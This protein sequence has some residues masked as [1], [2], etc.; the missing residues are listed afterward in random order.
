MLDLVST[1]AQEDTPPK[2]PAF[3]RH[4]D[5]VPPVQLSDYMVYTEG[6]PY[7][8]YAAMR[9]NAPVCWCTED[10]FS[11]FWA[12]TRY[13][14]IRK[15]ELDTQTFSSQRG[16]INMNYGPQET[17]H[18]LLNRA[19]FD[20]M[21]CLDAPVHLQLRR[22][23]MP[24]FTAN[25]VAELRRKVDA[26]V[27]SLLDAMAAKGPTLDLV[28]N[29]SAELP[30]FT[31]SEIL[32]IPEMD[33]PK[34]VRWMHYLEQAQ[35]ALT[36][37]AVGDMDPAFMFEFLTN[38]QEMFDYGQSML[39][40]RR[41]DPR[42][43]LLSAIAN[44]EIDGAPLPDEFLDGSWL[45]IVFAG[46]DTTRNSISGAMRLLNAFPDQR[47]KLVTTPSLL[48][49]FVHESIRMVSPVIYMRRTATRD[50][51]IN[52]QKIAEGEKVLM[53][54][55]AANRD[56]A[57]FTNPDQFDITRNN[58]RDHIAFGLGPHV[59]LGQRVANMQLEAAFAQ[60]LARF[61]GITCTGDMEIAPSNFVH[62]ISRLEVNL[63]ER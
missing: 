15:V 10:E 1:T 17:R 48:P 63:S 58:A 2:D 4:Y 28:E 24:F 9:E 47:D 14:D 6:Q 21:I 19:S 5:Y 59:C 38:V 39:Q 8:A 42:D 54:Y 20:N 13:E 32:G 40:A 27:S 25:Y 37:D 11:G 12:L 30:L 18:P 60:I 44:A 34:L 43:D 33:R 16:G 45:L 31:L 7:A 46:N 56:P 61:P 57:V 23:H 36:R 26:Q 51:E 41:A 52:G 55:A 62:A 35:D 53:Y 3:A 22:E 29:F 49:G 50:T